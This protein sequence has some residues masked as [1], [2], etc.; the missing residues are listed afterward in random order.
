MSRFADEY[1]KQEAS[2][3][4]QYSV[5]P[6]ATLEAA[7]YVARQNDAA[8]NARFRIGRPHSDC[9]LIARFVEG[10]DPEKYPG[11]VA[12]ARALLEETE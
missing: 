3:A 6:E 9:V 1:E 11:A 12:L 5:I 7:R 10:L 4:Q 8:I 2:A